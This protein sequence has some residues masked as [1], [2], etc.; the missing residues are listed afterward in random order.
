MSAIARL[1]RFDVSV[2]VARASR[3]IDGGPALSSSVESKFIGLL[4][5]A[6]L[7]DM[8]ESNGW[9]T[10]EWGEALD[11]RPKGTDNLTPVAQ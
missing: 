10:G 6:E 8:Y 1:S 7:R 2:K 3:L 5:A 9:R 4:S 11:I